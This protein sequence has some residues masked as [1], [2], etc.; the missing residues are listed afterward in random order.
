ML[1]KKRLSFL[2]ALLAFLAFWQSADAAIVAGQR[3]MWS[4]LKAGDSILLRNANCDSYGSSPASYTANGEQYWMHAAKLITSGWSSNDAVAMEIPSSFAMDWV[5]VL[6][7]GPAAASGNPTFYLKVAS[8]GQYIAMDGTLSGNYRM[9]YTDAR[10]EATAL[11]PTAVRENQGQTAGGYTTQQDDSTMEL[12]HVNTDGTICY[13][14][15]AW[16]YGYTQYSTNAAD[17]TMWNVYRV[18]WD[19]SAKVKLQALINATSDVDSYVVGTAPGQFDE[20]AVSNFIE[21]RDLAV[22]L[23]YEDEVTEEQWEAQLEALQTAY[24][25]VIASR[26]KVSEGY[27][28]FICGYTR[29]KELQDKDKAIQAGTHGELTWAAKDSLSALQ[30]FK[31]TVLSDTT[32]SIQ[33]V[34]SGLYIAKADTDAQNAVIQMSATQEVPQTIRNIGNTDYFYLGNI[35]NA[36]VADATAY[37][38]YNHLSGRGISGEVV[39]NG[40]WG[41]NSGSGWRLEQVTD[42][43]LISQLEA[44]E[45]PTSR[46]RPSTTPSARR[47][48]RATWCTSSSP[49]SPARRSSTPTTAAPASSRRLPTS[50]T[51]TL[52]TTATSRQ[53]GTPRSWATQA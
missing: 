32:F 36:D 43:E 44:R 19:E 11:E 24:D 47:R 51:V 28:N 30:L 5:V 42:Q 26:V 14:G 20:T 10:A 38:T 53:P 1:M 46:R 16:N 22:D 23:T 37:H 18:A 21:A 40:E 39:L 29:Y 41:S 3:I 25:A 34:A 6:E 9:W 13:F 8:T 31:V 17:Q 15:A 50:S 27:Y 33:N 7:S 52:T 2:T 49:Q 4:D 48:P 35:A 45:P 12:R